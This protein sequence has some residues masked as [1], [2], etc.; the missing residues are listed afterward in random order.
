MAMNLAHRRLCS[1]DRCAKTVEQYLR[2]WILADVNLGDNTLE[3]GPGYGA[4]LTCNTVSPATLPDRLRAAGFGDVDVQARGPAA[5]AGGEGSVVSGQIAC[6]QRSFVTSPR[7][8]AIAE[9]EPT[10][11]G[12]RTEA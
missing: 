11:A 9:P 5:L 1:S 2:P 8:S 6:R 12:G 7:P 3:I 4:I 10:A